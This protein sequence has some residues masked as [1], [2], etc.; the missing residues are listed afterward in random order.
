LS[1]DGSVIY[2]G[3]IDRL[4]VFSA[5][6]GQ[7][8]GVLGGIA[9]FSL[10]YAGGAGD[11][12]ECLVVSDPSQQKLLRVDV[13]DPSN[14][15]IVGSDNLP[16]FQTLV[17]SD[18]N[19][20]GVGGLIGSTTGTDLSAFA[21]SGCGTPATI[22]GGASG[23]FNTLDV[24]SEPA[25]VTGTGLLMVDGGPNG[26]DVRDDW[27][28]FLGGVT[29][30][31]VEAA[32]FLTVD[33]V[34]YATPTQIKLAD[35]S[36]PAHPTDVG[37]TDVAGVTALERS[38]S[39]RLWASSTDSRIH[40]LDTSTLE[41]RLRLAADAAIE[42]LTAAPQS[43]GVQK[44][45]ARSGSEIHLFRDGDFVIEPTAFYPFAGNGLGGRRT[46]VDGT[47][48]LV[49][50]DLDKLQLIDVLT[51]EVLDDVTQGAHAF[52]VQNDKVVAL[53][54]GE[55]R[56]YEIDPNLLQLTLLATLFIGTPYIDGLEID[57]NGS[58]I[59]AGGTNDMIT[60][61]ELNDLGLEVKLTVPAPSGLTCHD[62]SSQILVAGGTG[63]SITW[64]ISDLAN[65]V[66]KDT[67]PTPVTAVC[68]AN[69]DGDSD[70]DE[71]LSAQDILR[72]REV[73]I[74]GVKDLGEIDAQLEQV[75][76]R[77][78]VQGPPVR[79]QGG[80]D[81]AVVYAASSGRVVAVDVTD[82]AAAVVLGSFADPDV[83]IR[84]LDVADDGLYL[85]Q[86]DGAS[87]LPLHRPETSTDVDT[88]PELP[89]GFD[90]V[91][92]AAWPNPASTACDISWSQPEGASASL[93][94]FDARG[95][96]VR[97]LD[98]DVVDDASRTAHWDTR[99]EDGR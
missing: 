14:P 96:R 13:S 31:P 94:V 43:P 85:M 87:V 50:A 54:N 70:P 3:A 10:D 2:A 68:V 30:A 51:G 73:R 9:A 63:G 18:S 25:P 95:K 27:G 29:G 1:R 60:V 8:L 99:D 56:A 67:D 44:L 98:P 6:T 58:L 89:S 47:E 93:T 15:V 32:T 39:D 84:G 79:A 5:E 74:N 88:N 36:D 59:A 91:L 82:P 61:V 86:P 81:P 12:T 7:Q 97:R 21:G 24:W 90:A 40:L 34:A 22:N 55:I 83:F 53:K 62:I 11:D 38:S 75:I 17:R 77:I 28:N 42:Q 23:S 41:A 66:T 26:L 16:G 72:L 4:L 57:E 37:W 64:D 20:A 45:A 78:R 69:L 46:S 92:S 35:V 71:I 33:R 80:S 52:D 48:L 19:P 65:P 76:D 49:I